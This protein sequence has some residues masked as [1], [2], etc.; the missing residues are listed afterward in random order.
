MSHILVTND[1][2]PK[3][4]GIQSYLYDLWSRL[5]PSSFE[6]LTIS[7]PGDY[8]FDA[9][10]K[11]AIHRLN[12]K[13]LL[14]TPK[15][16]HA[17]EKVIRDSQASFV[18]L[19]PVL[20]LGL[21][22]PQLGVPYGVI[23]HG[24]EITVP[25]RLPGTKSL[26]AKVVK[27]A[28][29]VISAG[30]YALREAEVVVGEELPESVVVLP[31]I[32]VKRFR[33]FSDKEKEL[34]RE[35]LFLPS[36]AFIITSVSRLVPRKGMD[37]LIE[38][39]ADLAKT[40]QNL[41]LAIAGVGRDY[42]RL[43]KLAI[44]LKAPVEF[45]HKVS[46]EDLPALLGASDLFAMICRNRWFSLEQE[47][48]GIVFNEAGAAGLASVAGKS[49]GVPEAVLDEKTGVIVDRPGD[50]MVAKQALAKLIDDNILRSEYGKAARFRMEKEL[51][52]DI[53]AK[54]LSDALKK[55]ENG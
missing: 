1:F 12:E 23:L 44:S 53:L 3:L 15:I 31:G 38:A 29:L 52:N 46:D 8:I 13:M 11:F 2:P 30:N 17:V 19:D 33:V 14:P 36:D 49:G 50:V 45:L 20:P 21:L 7:Y 39:V 34:A 41:F 28:D 27:N 40:R 6:V 35:K 24:A 5:D 42:Q 51:D 32:D 16:R 22:G 54:T 18:V 37:V 43:A 55:Y 26:L 10:Q 9:K 48:Y 47:G 25:A 4:G